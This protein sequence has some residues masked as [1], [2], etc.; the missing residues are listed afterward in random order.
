MIK[1]NKRYVSPGLIFLKNML[2]KICLNDTQSLSIERDKSSS[3]G[4]ASGKD[5]DDQGKYRSRV[6]P[7]S[8]MLQRIF[9]NTFS[10]SLPITSRWWLMHLVL[11][12]MLEFDLP[13]HADILYVE[14]LK[15]VQQACIIAPFLG[16]KG[17]AG[18]SF[19]SAP[20][21]LSWLFCFGLASLCGFPCFFAVNVLQLYYDSARLLLLFWLDSKYCVLG[22]IR[23]YKK[24]IWR[25][26]DEEEK[27]ISADY[28][29]E[30]GSSDEKYSNLCML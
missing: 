26:G 25:F 23:K 5:F 6:H 29:D 10:P 14:I 19:G 18:A 17:T 11:F 21:C 12:I 4:H 1:D 28:S 24:I 7:F 27:D 15:M 22:L 3:H 9:P 20:C 16:R 30:E 8:R 13:V 2:L